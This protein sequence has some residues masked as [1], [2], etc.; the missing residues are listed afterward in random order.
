MPRA[1][2]GQP[3]GGRDRSMRG[4]VAGSADVDVQGGAGHNPSGG[5]IFCTSLSRLDAY[6]SW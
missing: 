2:S 1:D 6:K 4:L 3:R 5:I